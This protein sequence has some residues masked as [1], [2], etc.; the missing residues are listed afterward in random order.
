M[1]QENR[2]ALSKAIGMLESLTWV[3]KSNVAEA[4]TL[5]VEVLEEVLKKEGQQ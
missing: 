2:E 1:T 5:A 3:V 4:L